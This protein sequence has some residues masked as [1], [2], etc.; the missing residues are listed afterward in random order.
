[1]KYSGPW[2][3]ASRGGPFEF[4]I[5]ANGLVSKDDIE[6]MR[7]TA[8][9]AFNVLNRIADNQR[10]TGFDGIPDPRGTP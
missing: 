9:L 1:M 4:S 3:W 8:V 6:F 2:E 7:Q 5:V 10:F